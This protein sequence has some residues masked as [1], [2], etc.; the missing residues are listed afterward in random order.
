MTSKAHKSAHSSAPPP[1][2][3]A[4]VQKCL[5]SLANVAFSACGI[6][7][8]MAGFYL[9]ADT[10]RIL[11]SRLLCAGSEQLN[12]LPQPLFY[13]VA[14]AL[15]GGGAVAVVAAMVG[16]WAVCL[17]NVC[18]LTIVGDFF[19]CVC[20]FFVCVKYKLG[21]RCDSMVSAN[22]SKIRIICSGYSVHIPLHF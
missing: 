7:L 12:E 2:P 19:D 1:K 17:N 21:Q 10:Q 3:S 15:A 9:F 11:M 22:Y 8:L 13:Y 5:L 20:L 14:L 4:C 18:M 16:W 6:G